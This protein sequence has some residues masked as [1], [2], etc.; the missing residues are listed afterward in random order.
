MNQ[1]VRSSARS[2]A[3]GEFHHAGDRVDEISHSVVH[4]LEAM[5]VRAVNRVRSE[6]A[7]Y[8]GRE[9]VYVDTAARANIPQ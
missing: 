7:Q 5:G 4:R 2:V 3:N 1:P 8:S 9:G 6:P